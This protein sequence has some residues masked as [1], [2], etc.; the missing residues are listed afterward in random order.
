M[1]ALGVTE[2]QIGLTV[3][4]SWFV[5]LVLAMIE[6]FGLSGEEAIHAVRA[7]RSMVHGFTTLE[8]AGGFGLPL[9]FDENFNRM[10][11]MFIR[12]L[13]NPHEGN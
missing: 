12:G 2:S 11:E 10:V 4:I 13:E 5:Q 9:N 3:S 6:S 7:L 8:A 1:L